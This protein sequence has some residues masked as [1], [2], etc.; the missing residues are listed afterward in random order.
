ME[1]IFAR[2][3]YFVENI[4]NWKNNISNILN[5]KLKLWNYTYS[6]DYLIEWT[7]LIFLLQG[8]DSIDKSEKT[9]KTREYTNMGVWF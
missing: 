7:V 9:W 2:E 8:F 3:V 5:E 6:S 4:E 1:R